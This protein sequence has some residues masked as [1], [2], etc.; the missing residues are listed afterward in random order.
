MLNFLNNGKNPRKFLCDREVS[1]LKVNA[2]KKQ[3]D[4]RRIIW[5]TLRRLTWLSLRNKAWST[6][7]CFDIL[8]VNNEGFDPCEL[9]QKK[10][11]SSFLSKY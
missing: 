2:K 1:Q 11:L 3:K 4:F 9:K 7:S 6:T 10:K 5:S 8:F